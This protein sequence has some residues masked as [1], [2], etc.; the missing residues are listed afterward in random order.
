MN[1]GVQIS[2]QDSD[3]VSF[4]YMPR[5]GI[6]GLYD[7]FIFNFFWGTSTLFS[8]ISLPIHIPVNSGQVFLFLHALANICYLFY[9]KFI[10]LI[11]ITKPVS[12]YLFDNSQYVGLTSELILGPVF[13]ISDQ[14]LRGKGFSLP[15][16]TTLLYPYLIQS[17]AFWKRV[18]EKGH[19]IVEHELPYSIFQL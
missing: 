9:D 11:L 3:F 16:G 17:G 12:S 6:A 14:Q 4:E 10:S 19:L 18:R 13:I 1:M 5:S 2:L 8:I 7:S 15:Q